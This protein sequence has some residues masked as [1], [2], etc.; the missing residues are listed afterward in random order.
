MVL[1]CIPANVY[2]YLIRRV[3]AAWR[4]IS[5][6]NKKPA[7]WTCLHE[8]ANH[9]R[10]VCKN[11]TSQLCISRHDGGQIKGPS[12]TI[13]LRWSEGFQGRPREA[14]PSGQLYVCLVI[15]S[16]PGWAYI[17]LN[18]ICLQLHEQS[19]ASLKANC[20]V[21]IKYVTYI[22]NAYRHVVLQTL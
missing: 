6:A 14:N 1:T 16:Q 4:P 13:V 15:F 7:Q 9:E 17:W 8:N 18:T 11:L 21:A 10:S 20:L 5:N 2:T 22:C 12:Y 19:Y 3:I